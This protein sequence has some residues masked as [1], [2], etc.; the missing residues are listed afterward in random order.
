MILNGLGFTDRPLSLSPQFFENKALDVLFREGVE[1]SYFNRFKLG[2]TLDAAYAHGCERLFG[3][4]AVS[5]CCQ[6]GVESRF[7]CEDTTS[8][9]LTGQDSFRR[10]KQPSTGLL[11]LPV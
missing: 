11:C 10:K 1:A 4:L 8:F 2:R 9:S 3:E 7:G 5:V 6:E